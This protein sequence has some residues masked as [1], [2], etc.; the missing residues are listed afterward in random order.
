MW[1]RFVLAPALGVLLVNL[2]G[3]PTTP[4][5][6]DVDTMPGGN[7]DGFVA[8][9]LA[10]FDLQNAV[11][12]L[13]HPLALATNDA[14]VYV[15]DD[16]AIRSIDL[17]TYAS[18]ASR[19]TSQ[20]VRGIA[21][22]ASGDV[23]TVVAGEVARYTGGLDPVGEGLSVASDSRAAFLRDP[24]SGNFFLRE[25]L[26]GDIHVIS[27]ATGIGGGPALLRSI[28]YREQAT[29][30]SGAFSNAMDLDAQ[31]GRLFVID[32]GELL[33]VNI[34][35]D[36]GEAG[37]FELS[38]QGEA[39]GVIIDSAR[40]RLYVNLIFADTDTSAAR[41]RAFDL[42]TLEQVAD[43]VLG[44]QL[45]WMAL[46]ADRGRLAVVTRTTTSFDVPVF[47]LDA[48]DLS[49]IPYTLVLPDEGLNATIHAQIAVD[50]T[51]NQLIVARDGATSR[52]EFYTL[53]D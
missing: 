19:T 2:A 21:T 8:T 1:R 40:R 17:Q 13:A 45:H 41:V 49:L 12:A 15:G 26:A 23:F 33:I 28:N 53:P 18:Q 14:V 39:Q 51:R 36:G 34:S 48:D 25:A 7:G 11:G 29:S 4:T 6:D 9:L 50:T 47:L 20:R 27:P 37:S 5:G 30:F 10:T 38:L 42:D 16:D 3:C 24:D 46:D 52:V 31:T 32:N 22:A 43:R 35:D 44:N